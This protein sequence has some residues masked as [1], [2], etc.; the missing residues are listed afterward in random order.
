MNTTD[1]Y[2]SS[3]EELVLS[4][5]LL[6]NKNLEELASIMTNGSRLRL[7]RLD[8]SN[9]K[10]SCKGLLLIVQALKANNCVKLTHLHFDKSNLD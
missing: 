3:L 4:N 5:N 7:K 2:Q 9:N 6:A 1:N 8:L 10:F